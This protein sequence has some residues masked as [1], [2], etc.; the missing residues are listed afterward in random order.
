MRCWLARVLALGLGCLSLPATAAEAPRDLVAAQQPAAAQLIKALTGD[1]TLFPR[2]A[3]LCDTFGPRLSG[4]ANLEKAISWIVDQM[5]KDGLDNAHGEQVLVPH[6]VRGPESAT[7]L[8]P[9]EQPLVMLGLGGSV[10][11]PP[12]GITAD[13]VVVHSF[14]ELDARPERVKGKIVVFVPTYAGY[15][16]T[17]SYR[18]YGAVRAAAYG[19]VAVLNRSV[20]PYSLGAPH[21]GAMVYKLRDGTAAVQKLPAAALSVEDA[22][23]LARL[24]ERGERLRIRLRMSAATLADAPSRNIVAELRGTEY[25]EEVV[26]FGGHIDS[27]DVGQ[28]AQDDAGNCV[29]AWHALLAMQ[30]LGLRPRRTIRL[31]LWTNEENGRAGAKA[32]ARAH[33]AD[34]HV[35]AIEADGGVFRP[36]GWSFSG[37]PAALSSVHDLANLLSPLGA[38]RIDTPGGGADVQPLQEQGVPVMGLGTANDRYFWFHHSAADTIDKVDPTDLGQTAA[39]LAV[40]AY[41]AAQAL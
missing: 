13:A 8:L 41:G 25:P 23:L 17:V 31:V 7:L 18:V 39:A 11:T 2:L 1:K 36:T 29:A 33:A 24:Q 21:T 26:V 15:E 37:S 22:E 30:R 32:Y 38:T 20:T 10:G 4:S 27:W 6:W 34:H 16:E 12:E 35:L 40:M 3:Y 14:A 19:A 28:G 9:R 5:R